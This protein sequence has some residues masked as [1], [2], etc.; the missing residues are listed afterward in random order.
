MLHSQG[1]YAGNIDLVLVAKPELPIETV[2]DCFGLN[3]TGAVEVLKAVGSE[4]TALG[5]E[6]TFYSRLLEGVTVPPA[7]VD[8]YWQPGDGVP[9]VRLG[10]LRCEVVV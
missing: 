3:V 1:E 6:L 2:V 8:A 10:Q 7:V 5:V 9:V 4:N